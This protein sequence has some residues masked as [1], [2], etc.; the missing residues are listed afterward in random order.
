[1]SDIP[2]VEGQTRK[3]LYRR[4]VSDIRQVINHNVRYQEEQYP[5]MVEKVNVLEAVNRLKT[6]PVC[7]ADLSWDETYPLEKSCECG[8]FVI[9]DVW[10]DGDV[11]F[12]FKMVSPE[13]LENEKH[14]ATNDSP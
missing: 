13:K 3:D 14:G 1:M 8:D 6:C 11:S 5:E 7:G 10:L 12:A 2:D 4:F 9:S